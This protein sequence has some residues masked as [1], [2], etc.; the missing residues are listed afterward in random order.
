MLII[1]PVNILMFSETDVY[2]IISH[3][4]L[5]LLSANDPS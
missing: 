5:P 2:P 3:R 1:S 4:L